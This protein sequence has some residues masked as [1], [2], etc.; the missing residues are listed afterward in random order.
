MWLLSFISVTNVPI[1][2]DFRR[3]A[4][5]DRKQPRKLD[6]GYFVFRV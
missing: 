6:A 4:P 1:R 5:A 2:E 3:L